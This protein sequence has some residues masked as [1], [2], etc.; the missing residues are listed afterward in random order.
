MGWSFLYL[1]SWGQLLY[2]QVLQ[3]AAVMDPDLHETL[4]WSGAR[5]QWAW[6]GSTACPAWSHRTRHQTP[7]RLEYQPIGLST[8]V[9]TNTS[10]ATVCRVCQNSDCFSAQVNV[11]FVRSGSTVTLSIDSIV[12]L[13]TWIH[14]K[15]T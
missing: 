3:T 11:R 6:H 2:I 5:G 12:L 7:V 14:R 9:R 13:Q 1:E 8:Y 10:P 15:K 4:A